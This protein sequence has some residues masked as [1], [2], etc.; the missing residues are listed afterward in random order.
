MDDRTTRA[1][2]RRFEF[3]PVQLKPLLPALAILWAPY[4]P[5]RVGEVF[6][7]PRSP[8][9]VLFGRGAENG[10]GPGKRHP[11]RQRPGH[12]EPRPPLITPTISRVQLRCWT[13][14]AGKLHMERVGRCLV[15][16]GGREL[17]RGVLEQHDVVNLDNQ[18]LLLVVQRPEELPPLPLGMP[19]PD[20]P[21]GGPDTFGMVGESAAMW[22]F[23]RRLMALARRESAHVLLLGPSGTGKELAARAVHAMS[24]RRNGPL[25]MRN[26]AT[27]PEGLVDAE[28]FGNVRDFPN[29]GMAERP[30]LVGE[31]NRGFLF[32]D[33]FGEM[34]HDLQAHLLRV[35]DSGDYQRLGDATARRSDFRLIA[36]TNRTPEELKHDMAARLTPVAAPNLNDRR[37]DIPLLIRHL[38]KRIADEE[39]AVATAFFEGGTA[40]GEPRVTPDLMTRL[41]L[42]TYTT[43]VRELG[44]LLW[45]AVLDSD[46]NDYVG[47]P[48]ART[49]F[50][51]RRAWTGAGARDGRGGGDG[52]ILSSERRSQAPGRSSRSHDGG[53]G[54]GPADTPL[55]SVLDRMERVRL[56]LFR[57][58]GFD[59]SAAARDPEYGVSRVTA[60]THLWT[61]MCKVLQ[62]T[63][64]DVGSAASFL[65]GG[66]YGLEARVR[67]RM[68]ERIERLRAELKARGSQEVRVRLKRRYRGAYLW[69]EPLIDALEQGRLE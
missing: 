49:P 17:D 24:S 30:G 20:F 4:E 50:A 35:M 33:E 14:E 56:G 32:L 9:G 45:D 57:K 3:A 66:A 59:A 10:S 47:I 34:T 22:A 51:S 23:R 53:D 15:R 11:I 61:M 46:G 60:N 55:A 21:F 52:D 8:H 65:S 28:L 39:P 63:D 42:H 25:V 44:K 16:V 7:V 13:D 19:W 68:T 18:M 6:L 1:P 5:D 37:E 62:W 2:S 38:L 29:R 58:H 27:I 36:A 41:V 43:H 48:P 69:V 12:N 31:A 54:P 40:A 64:W 67:Q 26:A